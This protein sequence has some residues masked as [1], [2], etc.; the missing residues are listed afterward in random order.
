MHTHA[1]WITNIKTYTHIHTHSHNT[2]TTDQW[3]HPS[4]NLHHTHTPQQPYDVSV[5]HQ[6]QA[7][8]TEQHR[9]IVH[10]PYCPTPPNTLSPSHNTHN[11]SP[12]TMPPVFHM[13]APLTSHKAAEK[14]S[15]IMASRALMMMG[16]PIWFSNINLD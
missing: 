12:A 2:H 16:L 3:V 7:P 14:A 10:L 1:I 8:Y 5:W 15:F 6:S 9:T 11:G 4:P 13:K